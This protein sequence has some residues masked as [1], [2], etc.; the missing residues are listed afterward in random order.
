[1]NIQKVGS[2]IKALRES[3]GWTQIQLASMLNVTDK[4][5]SKWESGA[6]LPDTFLFP[7]LSKL[8]GVSSDELLSGER[9]NL[10]AI[11]TKYELALDIPDIKTMEA[12][13]ASDDLSRLDEKGK[14]F[15][16]YVIQQ[17]KAH[18]IPYCLKKKLF[19]INNE[20]IITDSLGNR[21]YDKEI[22]AM[23][24]SKYLLVDWRRS[25]D[26]ESRFTQR[27]YSKEELNLMIEIART[28]SAKTSNDYLL[29]YIYGFFVNP[30]SKES[31]PNP[32]TDELLDTLF[33]D[34]KLHQWIPTKLQIGY[35]SSILVPLNLKFSDKI[36]DYFYQNKI[37]FIDKKADAKQVLS[38]YGYRLYVKSQME[39][40]NFD[41][42]LSEF[43]IYEEY[44]KGN[45]DFIDR[46]I[47]RKQTATELYSVK[48][49]KRETYD[50]D[51]PDRRI[52][53]VDPEK[54][55]EYRIAQFFNEDYPDVV[56]RM[57]Q[58]NKG[59]PENRPERSENGELSER[60]SYTGMS[61]KFIRVL[62]ET[63]VGKV[64]SLEE[65]IKDLKKKNK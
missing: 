46:V 18:L 10:N 31:V 27:K 51:W 41:E 24:I 62:F 26:G 37:V 7:Q 59:I 30:F 56:E 23:I 13:L 60:T 14:S 65:E 50:R 58:K 47:D 9:L 12:F 43:D 57:I 61:V 17:N 21:Q 44:K 8:F 33:I 39:Y 29:G 53:I 15:L 4:A 63:L 19:D 55:H 1:M 34:L 5:V 3:K 64:T 35:F 16:Y 49:L 20:G 28:E 48:G 52:E 32:N 54:V 11:K 6:G 42:I 45:W 25:V 38:D 36:V 40:G 2:F 22:A